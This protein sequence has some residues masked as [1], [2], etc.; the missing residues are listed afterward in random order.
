M[1]LAAQIV[2]H[3]LLRL[4]R[5]LLSHQRFSAGIKIFILDLGHLSVA[6]CVGQRVA[7]DIAFITLCVNIA[8]QQADNIIVTGSLFLALTTASG[9]APSQA[10]GTFEVRSLKKT[11][12]LYWFLQIVM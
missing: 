3:S 7:T 6:P 8:A 10:R 5:P 1:H 2:S 11:P 9:R 4:V 12:H